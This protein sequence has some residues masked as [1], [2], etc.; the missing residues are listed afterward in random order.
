MTPTETRPVQ[1]GQYRLHLDCTRG[2]HHHDALEL[3]EREGVPA[4]RLTC[5]YCGGPMGIREIESPEVEE[6]EVPEGEEL[7]L[8]YLKTVIVRSSPEDL[9]ALEERVDGLSALVRE[10]LLKWREEQWAARGQA[11]VVQFLADRCELSAGGSVTARKLHNA[12]GRFCRQQNTAGWMLE[13]E[14][15]AELERRGYPLSGDPPVYLG[16]ALKPDKPQRRARAG[17]PVDP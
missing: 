4:E 17:K 2:P 10:R 6:R 11:L 16:I 1:D 9:S 7:L 8:E 3:A 15:D 12:F 5:P 14:L 13:G